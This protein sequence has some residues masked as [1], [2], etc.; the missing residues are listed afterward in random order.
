MFPVLAGVAGLGLVKLGYDWMVIL[1][2]RRRPRD[3]DKP[4]EYYS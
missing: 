4:W 1:R 2:S 3:P